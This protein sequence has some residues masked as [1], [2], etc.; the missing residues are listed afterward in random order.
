MADNL[1]R[2]QT[3]LQALLQFLQREEIPHVIIGG[4]AVSFLSQPRA[5]AD[6]D[7]LTILEDDSRISRLLK[8]AAEFSLAPPITNAEAFALEIRVM[9]LVQ[10]VS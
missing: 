8:A 9:L 1:N 3:P 6:I 7:V 5:T 2:F 4:V 10:Q